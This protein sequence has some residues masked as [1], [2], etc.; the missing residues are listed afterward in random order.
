[1]L[2]AQLG[3]RTRTL[4]ARALGATA[5]MDFLAVEA[6]TLMALVR[7]HVLLAFHPASRRVEIAASCASTHE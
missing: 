6:V 4:L 2:S 7:Y 5:A 3:R 1:M